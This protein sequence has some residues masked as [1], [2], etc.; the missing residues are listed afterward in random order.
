MQLTQLTQNKKAMP[1]VPGASMPDM[2]KMMWGMNIW[3]S[4]MMWLMVFG[5]N[6]AVGLYLLTSCLFSIC[7]F[8]RRYRAILKAKW[9]E[10][11]HK[12]EPTIIEP[13]K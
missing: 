5:L 10:K 1:K 4:L 9:N 2:S 3:M 12:N 11:F 6:S 13:S 7:Q 8:S